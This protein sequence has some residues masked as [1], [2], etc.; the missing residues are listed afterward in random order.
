MEVQVLFRTF[1]WLLIFYILYY[2]HVYIQNISYTIF[3]SLCRTV[4]YVFIYSRM[5]GNCI[6]YMPSITF[7]IAIWYNILLLTVQYMIHFYDNIIAGRKKS[8]IGPVFI[9]LS[10][11][12]V[13]C[14]QVSIQFKRG[15]E[16]GSVLAGAGG[17]R[18]SN[19]NVMDHCKWKE[20]YTKSLPIQI[21][22]KGSSL[23]MTILA[24]F[25]QSN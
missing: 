24:Q 1:F 3:V 15:L 7:L 18:L 25:L 21:A 5:Y 2:H 19:G 17:A 11:Q 9:P 13:L 6:T 20:F 10:E 8:Y 22:M 12:Q 23:T 16:E 4:S 14:P